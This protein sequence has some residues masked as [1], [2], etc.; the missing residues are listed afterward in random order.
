VNSTSLKVYPIQKILEM[1]EQRVVV[2]KWEGKKERH[3]EGGFGILITLKSSSIQ[4]LEMYSRTVLQKTCP[5]LLLLLLPPPHPP[6][7]LPPPPRILPPPHRFSLSHALPFP[8]AYLSQALLLPPHLPSL[9]PQLL[10]FQFCQSEID[11][12]SFWTFCLQHSKVPNRTLPD[13]QTTNQKYFDQQEDESK[14]GWRN[15]RCPGPWCAGC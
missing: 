3:Q 13:L 8:L 14:P 7:P 6:P 15:P 10:V 12:R 2:Q 1:V 11:L 9:S 4:S 5:H